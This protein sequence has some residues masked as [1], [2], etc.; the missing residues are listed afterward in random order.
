V[1]ARTVSQG[2]E[3][4]AGASRVRYDVAK[5]G[6]NPDVSEDGLVLFG[7]E[8]DVIYWVAG[9]G[10]IKPFVECSSAEI[11]AII[12]THVTGPMTAL[13]AILRER[14]AHG[15]QSVQ[16]VMV[17]SSSAWKVREREAAYATAQAGKAHLARNL[18]V[19]M[20]R[21]L[22]GSKVLLVC[23]GGMK[24]GFFEGTDVDTSAFMDPSQVAGVICDAVHEQ[25][26]PYQELHVVRDA[27]GGL[28]LTWGPK[29]P[30]TLK[31][32]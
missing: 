15:Q 26:A 4:L 22:P 29:F 6:L 24:T 32:G 9:Q 2:P 13:Q 21:D 14:I 31:H 20:A 12:R 10:L 27:Q 25:T 7:A 1:S 19:E 28:D 11:D 8:A 17:S 30:Q 23:P 3:F 18:A 16:L 5:A